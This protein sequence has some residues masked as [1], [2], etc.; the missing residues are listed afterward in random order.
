MTVRDRL[1][2]KMGACLA[3]LVLAACGGGGSG[4]PADTAPPPPPPPAVAAMVEAPRN[5]LEKLNTDGGTLY[6]YDQTIHTMRSMP[7]GGGAVD[8]VARGFTSSTGD[9]SVV[10]VANGFYGVAG[11]SIFGAARLYWYP[12]NPVAATEQLWVSSGFDVQHVVS[13]LAHADGRLYWGIDNAVYRYTLPNGPIVRLAQLPE[14]QILDTQV[15]AG[16]VYVMTYGDTPTSIYRVPVAGG[17]PEPVFISNDQIW[18]LKTGFAVAGGVVYFVSGSNRL[19]AVDVQTGQAT[20]LAQSDDVR[21]L[22][23]RDRNRP[24]VVVWGDSVYWS[25][26]NNSGSVIRR[27]S[28]SSR[29][30]EEIWRGDRV[31]EMIGDASGGV[32]WSTRVVIYS[33]R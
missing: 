4:G 2:R 6:F 7:V 17:T 27:I 15:S 13:G 1:Q 20:V 21:T 5:G 31:F 11:G 3:S 12:D 19:A 9:P 29:Q 22:E 24:Q 30:V 25:V 14:T 28:L 10:R 33:F 26:S 16:W 23:D 32:Y 8:D 18:I